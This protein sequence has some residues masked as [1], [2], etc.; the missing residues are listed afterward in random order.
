MKNTEAAPANRVSKLPNSTTI[1]HTRAGSVLVNCPPET[2][3]YV[4]ANGHEVPRFIVL[5]EDMPAGRE[6]G[7]T[8]FVRHGINHASIEFLLYANYFVQNRLTRV[9]ARTPEQAAR[10]AVIL[11]ETLVGPADPVEFDG[12]AWLQRECRAVSY[13][14]KISRPPLPEDLCRIEC[15]DEAG[16][17][18][19]EPG[20]ILEVGPGGDD[21]SF[22]EDGS[23][24]AT[25][26]AAI[27]GTPQPL[28]LA[29][30]RP[31]LLQQLTLQFIGGSD[32]FDPH[33]ITTCFLA[34]LSNDVETQATLFDTAAF[35]RQRLGNLGL[36]A[37]QISEVV[38]SHLHED[39]LAGL[40]ELLL[41]GDHRLRVITSDL[42]YRSLLRVLSSMLALPLSETAALFDYLPLNPGQ[43]LILGDR[44]FEAIYAV[45]SIPTIALR[46][47]GLYY[48]GDMRYDE[49]FFEDL[50]RQG[51]LSDERRDRLIGFAEGA[52]I[53]VQDAGGGTIHTTVTP[54]LLQSL[55]AKG[56]R[57]VLAHT[58]EG[59]LPDEL[60]AYSDQVEIARSGHVI[61]LGE[62]RIK[63]PDLEI[64]ETI[65]ACPLF[66]RLSMEE[67]SQLALQAQLQF[68]QD[69]EWVMT[70]GQTEDGCL[71]LV[72]S[73]LIEIRGSGQ[74]GLTFVAGRGS[75]I[76]E[77][78]ILLPGKL[79][80]HT[81]RATARGD[82]QLLRFERETI[83]KIA[84]TLNLKAAY[85]RA[86]WLGRQPLFHHLQWVSLLDLALDFEPRRLA[87]GRTLFRYGDPGFDSFLLVS[88]QIDILSARE[89]LVDSMVGPSVFFGGQAALYNRL[90]NATAVAATAVEVWALPAPVLQRLQI[91][92]PPLALHLRA[93]ELGRTGEVA[94]P[95][96]E[97]NSP[98]AAG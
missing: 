27:Q 60:S 67:R 58:A 66:V 22:Y 85:E 81:G 68:W 29:P 78:D 39:H 35:M 12:L 49:A 76:G 41:M 56:Q 2:L 14:P 86:D 18:E 82:G 36:S 28:A 15:L 25:V 59:K 31:L 57:I 7:S 46:V 13:F 50:V 74:E 5:P 93:V 11:Q 4:L 21:L 30:A 24:I 87:K 77:R 94:T 73:G 64:L 62:M 84:E 47:N 17:F 10:L 91:V 23:W 70:D 95:V 1:V 32:G 51:V 45:H 79:D 90:R 33:G 89:E 37:S 88:G 40:P 9:I 63:S 54:E 71:Y 44:K 38:I 52:D 65:E 72:H 53:L 20:V 75:T 34:Y 8:G 43:P 16:I 69:G 61:A 3:K 98:A 26:S 80:H 55:A 92:Y 42:I 6:L 48:S 96:Q 19:L 83:L 97:E